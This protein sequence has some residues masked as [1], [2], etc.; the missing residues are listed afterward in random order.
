MKASVPKLF[1]CPGAISSS[2]FSLSG[3]VLADQRGRFQPL[4]ELTT[5][6]DRSLWSCQSPQTHKDFRPHAPQAAHNPHGSCAVQNYKPLL[7]APATPFPKSAAINPPLPLPSH[8]S[9]PDTSA[10]HQ[11]LAP[12]QQPRQLSQRSRRQHR[13]TRLRQ[14]LTRLQTRR[15]VPKPPDRTSQFLQHQPRRC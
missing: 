6:W 12:R 1:N 13:K 7:Y 14:I 15:V 2:H 9:A 11:R 10:H 3:V 4:D 5:P 8:P